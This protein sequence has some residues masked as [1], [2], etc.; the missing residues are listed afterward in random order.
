MDGFL[1]GSRASIMLD[2]VF[3]AM[4]VVVPVLLWSIYQ[5]KYRQRY[6]LHKRVQVTMSVILL[7]T[8][9]L[10]EI[11]IRLNDWRPDAEPSPYYG[12][13][14]NTVLAVHLVFAIST[15]L[16]WAV[17]ITQALRKIPNPPGPCAYSPKHIRL[18]KLA[19]LDMCLTAVTGWTF[20]WMA[21]MAT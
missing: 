4:F 12:S 21:F 19:A 6:L 1:P 3:L 20:Y 18:A 8:V 7:V 15:F 16:L 17:T 10:F 5:V 9:G 14:L 11:D 2:V 13:T